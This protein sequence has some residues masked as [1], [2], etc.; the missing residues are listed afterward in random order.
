MSHKQDRR[1]TS[2]QWAKTKKRIQQRDAY[3]CQW[4][5]EGCTDYADQVDHIEP[6]ARGGAFWDESNLCACCAHCNQLRYHIP[7]GQRGSYGTRPEDPIGVGAVPLPRGPR[8]TLRFADSLGS[9][10]KPKAGLFKVPPQRRWA[11][12]TADYSRRPSDDD[13]RSG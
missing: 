9:L 1:L 3:R 5:L 8:G 7:A 6:R 4:R 13:A 12:V 10:Q 2:R 11:T